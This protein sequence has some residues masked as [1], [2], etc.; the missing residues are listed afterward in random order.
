MFT[1]E[2][3]DAIRAASRS[4]EQA[5]PPSQR[6][7]LGQYFTGLPLGKLLAHLALHA[8]TRTVLDPMAGHGALLDATWEAATER[9][10]TIQRLDGI[11]IDEAT[12]EIC[13]DRLARMTSTGPGPARWLVTADAFDP[14]SIRALPQQAYDLV[15]TNPPYVRY[16]SQKRKGEQGDTIRAGLKAVL[17]GHLC[18]DEA[19]VWRAL[20]DGYSGLADLS[21]PAWILSAAMVR[22]GGQL[23]LVVPATWRS[24]DYADVIRYLMLRCFS[25]ECIVE[26]RHPGWFSDALIRTHLIVARRLSASEVA[27]PIKTRHRLPE[28]LWVQVSPEAATSGSLV[29]AACEGAYPEQAFAAWLQA[30][31]AGTRLGVSVRPFDPV[32]E[33]ISLE[34]RARRRRWYRNLDSENGHSPL[35]AGARTGDAAIVPGVLAEALPSGIPPGTLLN[36][37]EVGVIVGQGLRTGCNGFFYVTA[38]DTVGSEGTLIEVSRPF[39]AHRFVVP[40]SALRPVLRGQGERTSLEALRLPR[41]RVLDLRTWVLPEDKETVFAARDTYASKGEALPQLMPKELAAHVRLAAVTPVDRG[42]SDKLIPTL[43]AVRTNERTPRDAR[44]TPRFWYMLPDFAPRHLPAA[45]VPRINHN[46]PWVEA[47]LDPPVLIDANFS[48]FWAPSGNWTRYA[49]KALLNSVWC[50]VAMEALGTP[51]GGGALK[52]EAT[53][54]RHLPVPALSDSEKDELDSV[55][56]QLAEG[57]LSARMRVDVIVLGAIVAAMDRAPSLTGLAEAIEKRALLLSAARRRA[58]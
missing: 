33:Y 11:E 12:A 40:T 24:R 7:R 48:T 39:G 25:L 26:D 54:L 55:G 17:A 42:R 16:Q 30:G 6:K 51:M 1:G 14:A 13:R 2:I 10:I 19:S 23:A 9:G 56:K 38:C 43:S 29:G 8:N 3:R 15:I 5:L 47:N 52:L 32:D 50:R 49:L 22:P 34:R 27:K 46:L 41:G 37:E 57:R 4:Y 28:P 53:H 58:V 44:T 36:L 21:V 20:A 35:F 18:G 31:C 45:F